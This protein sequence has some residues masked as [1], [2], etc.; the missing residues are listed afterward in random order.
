MD[1]AHAQLRLL[2]VIGKA[3]LP[4]LTDLLRQG[5]RVPV[6][7]LRVYWASPVR[8]A[9]PRTAGSPPMARKS[10]P[11]ALRVSAGVAGNLRGDG[12]FHRDLLPGGELD[13]RGLDA[14]ARQAGG[15]SPRAGAAQGGLGV[16]AGEGL[17]GP[18]GAMKAPDPIEIEE[19]EV[20]RLVEQAQQGRR[21][22]AGQSHRRA[23][24][25]DH[26]A[27]PQQQPVLPERSRRLR[28]RCPHPPHRDLRARRRQPP[29]ERRFWPSQNPWPSSHSSVSG[30][31]RRLRKTKI[32]LAKGSS[33]SRCRHRRTKSLGSPRCLPGRGHR[34]VPPPDRSPE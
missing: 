20:E 19:A 7:L 10:L 31:P 3:E 18:V 1:T 8:R 14:R 27:L 9:Y 26:P 13:L 34:E 15:S 29:R 32:A 5:L 12:A 30:V 22:T 11:T 2:V 33:P 25:E 16:S 23:G 24:A 21:R 4:R 28:G 6:I 17:P